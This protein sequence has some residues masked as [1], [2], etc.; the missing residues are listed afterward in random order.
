LS[1]PSRPVRL[2][3]LLRTARLSALRFVALLRRLVFRPL[4]LVAATVAFDGWTLRAERQTVA[5]PVDASVHTAMVRFAAD[6]ISAG[7]LPWTSWFP[8]LALGSPQF[9]HYQGLAAVIAGVI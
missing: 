9:L 6:R 1:A 5:Y 8:Y 4:V 7:H 2:G 3:R